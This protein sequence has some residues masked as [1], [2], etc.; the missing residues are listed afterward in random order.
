M[1]SI[2]KE[3]PDNVR[4]FF[5]EIVPPDGKGKP[6]EKAS[7]LAGSICAYILYLEHLVDG[8]RETLWEEAHRD[9]WPWGNTPTEWEAD[10]ILEAVMERLRREW[11]ERS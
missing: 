8:L 9:L 11:E 10:N 4:Y 5:R 3:R 6:V 2:E 1:T 7:I